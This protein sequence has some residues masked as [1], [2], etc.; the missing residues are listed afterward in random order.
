MLTLIVAF[1]VVV[2]GAVDAPLAL[3]L[4]LIPARRVT[5]F[6]FP[7]LCGRSVAGFILAWECYTALEEL[8]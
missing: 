7:S 1:I 8:I 4:A 5:C 6:P 2:A 3:A